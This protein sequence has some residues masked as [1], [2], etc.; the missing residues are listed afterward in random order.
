VSGR[1]IHT[2]TKWIGYDPEQNYAQGYGAGNTEGA[3][4]DVPD[5]PNVSS[6]VLGLNV[7]LR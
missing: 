2:W 5:F 7:S 1:N 3:F 6:Y 4:G